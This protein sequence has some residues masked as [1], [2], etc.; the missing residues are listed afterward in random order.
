[1]PDHNEIGHEGE[2][3]DLSSFYLKGNLLEVIS[4]NMF[5]GAGSLVKLEICYNLVHTLESGAFRDLSNLEVSTYLLFL[6]KKC[7]MQGGW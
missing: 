6:F 1:M 2:P 5:C 7:Q 3:L 4:E